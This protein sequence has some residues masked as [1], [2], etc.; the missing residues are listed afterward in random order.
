ML[1]P[2]TGLAVAWSTAVHS[3]SS[4]RLYLTKT[5]N[6]SNN[7]AKRSSGSLPLASHIAPARLPPSW[8]THHLHQ[9]RS[10]PPSG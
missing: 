3:L 6:A 5:E 8:T 7:L 10:G 4:V 2:P 1:S 9:P